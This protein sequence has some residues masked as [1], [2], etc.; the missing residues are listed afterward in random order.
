MN[1]QQDDADDQEYKR[2]IK[3]WDTSFSV[4]DKAEGVPLIFRNKNTETRF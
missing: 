3:H 4:R 2:V 1:H